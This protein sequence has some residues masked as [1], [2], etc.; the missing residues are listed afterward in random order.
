MTFPASLPSIATGIR[1]SASIA[2]ACLRHRR[3][4]Y[5][6][7]GRRRVHGRAVRANQLPEMYAAVVL[8]GPDRL[9]RER[10]AS[11]LHRRRDA[12]LGRG[13][14]V[15]AREDSPGAA[16]DSRARSW[17]RW[18]SSPPSSSWQL[19]GRAQ[20]PLLVPT[21]S[22]VFGAGLETCGAT[23]DF[24]SDAGESLKRLAA[25]FLIGAAIGIGIGLLVGSSPRVQSHARAIPR[26]A[27]GRTPPIAIVPALIVILG[28][29]DA[30]ASPS[31]RS[32]SAS[33][34]SSTRPRACE[35][36]RSEVRDTASMLHSAGWSGSSASTSRPHFRRSWRGCASRSRL[37]LVLVVVS[38]FVGEG[39]GL[40]GYLEV[41]AVEV[42]SFPR[43]TP[44]S[45]S[46]GSRL[47]PE[48]ALPPRRAPRARLALRS[49]R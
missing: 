30:I 12:V 11:A 27:C 28:F 26:A 32:A 40:G 1:V 45:C 36:S 48:P 15:G 17:R 49:S 35:P 14:A 5:A 2:L 3:V 6:D 20:R 16:S 46:S 8:V 37:A 10:R 21:T 42:R 43:C 25:G 39:S 31:S 33:R 34:S 44:A 23:P 41:A 19:V 38:E 9:R 4:L 7:R 22:E 24:L 18:S 29:G 13:G 47:R